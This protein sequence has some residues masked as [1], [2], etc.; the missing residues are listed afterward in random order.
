MN[1]VIGHVDTLL[2]FYRSDNY[3]FLIKNESFHLDLPRL[4][5]AGPGVVVF[6]V[7]VEAEHKPYF[8]LER[9]IQLIDRFYRL[10]DETDDLVLV[11]DYSDIENIVAEKKIAGMLALE[12]AEGVFDLSALHTFYHLG[13]R[14]ISLTWN[15]RNRFAD[16]VGELEANG[17]LTAAGRELIKEMDRLGLAVDLSHIAPAGFND[18]IDISSYPVAASHSNAR[19]VC[20]HPR[21]L[22]DDQLFAIAEKNGLIGLNFCP[23]FLNKS[24][25]A[26]IKDVIK[27]INY[28]RDLIGIDYIG[29]GTDY[30][31]I[32]K[33]PKKLEDI[34]KLPLLKEALLSEGY[35]EKE[36]GKIFYYNWLNFFKEVL[37]G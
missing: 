32:T 22:S 2:N 34:S 27:H 28:I 37:G 35:Q 18:V 1:Y 5:K 11:E 13:V 25:K 36:I 20:D 3:D 31:G 16:G 26:E 21:N 4:K 8:A 12:G 10:L 30:D 7:Y 6:A 17:G 9:T 29:L 23:E 19:A 15:Q 24:G 33:T 14:M